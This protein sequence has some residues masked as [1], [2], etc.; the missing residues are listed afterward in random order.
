MPRNPEVTLIPEMS[1]RLDDVIKT[2]LVSQTSSAT[3]I[4]CHDVNER[5]CST[6]KSEYYVTNNPMD[7]V[8]TIQ[9]GVSTIQYKI[10][11]Y[12]LTMMTI[13][14]SCLLH[15]L[16]ELSLQGYALPAVRTAT[17]EP[18]CHMVPKKVHEQV[19]KTIYDTI[20]RRDCY[21]TADSVCANIHELCRVSQKPVQETVSRQECSSQSSGPSLIFLTNLFR[22]QGYLAK[23]SLSHERPREPPDDLVSLLSQASSV[24][25]KCRSANERKCSDQQSLVKRRQC[26]DVTDTVYANANKRK[27][28]TSKRPI[29]AIVVEVIV[30][31]KINEML[32]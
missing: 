30:K 9:D 25:P 23:M 2:R 31:I 17:P 5:K 24:I 7:A 6:N 12:I 11:D 26:Q 21:D 15:S 29:H 19:P 4:Q 10:L 27:C 3:L 18:V 8:S 1:L 20:P 28:Q 32:K 16:A 22:C 13:I 14:A